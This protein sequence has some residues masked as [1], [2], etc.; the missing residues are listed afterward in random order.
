M[1]A[2]EEGVLACCG[3]VCLPGDGFC[4]VVG[5]FD[6][7]LSCVSF[8]VL[9]RCFVGL[10][11]GYE[12]V[13]LFLEGGYVAHQKAHGV[14]LFH[15]ALVVVGFGG[16]P[17]GFGGE[18]VGA[19]RK[20]VAAGG[21]LYAGHPRSIQEEVN[22]CHRCDLGGGLGIDFQ[23][24]LFA[25]LV[26]AGVVGL[27]DGG[28]DK[29]VHCR[30]FHAHVGIHRNR[31]LMGYSVPCTE[32]VAR[33]GLW[34]PVETTQLTILNQ[35]FHELSQETVGIQR[36]IHIVTSLHHHYGLAETCLQI[37]ERSHV[38]VDGSRNARIGGDVEM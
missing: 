18:G 29:S 1:I 37:L 10:G 9:G 19:E 3:E 21:W 2:E 11:A 26:D 15:V 7:A 32:V 30:V 4:L 24:H 34:F 23:F 16:E 38:F 31:G 35:R 20:K 28:V 13:S 27:I 22:F 33:R 36:L 25:G 8:D 14:A 17:I 5:C 6:V 12:S